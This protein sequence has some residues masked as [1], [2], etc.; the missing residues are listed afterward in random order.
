MGR[1][2]PATTV[3][4]VSVDEGQGSGPPYRGRRDVL[5]DELRSALELSALVGFAVVQP[6]LGPFGESPETFTAAGASPGQIVVFAVVVAAAPLLALW[7]LGAASRVLGTRRRGLVQT[8]LVAVLAGFA[9]AGL[10]RHLGAGPWVRGAVGAILVGAVAVVH[11]RWEPGRLFLRYASPVPVVLV[12][13]FLLASPVAPL[14]RP[15]ALEIETV[16]GGDHPPVTWSPSMPTA[17]APS[18]TV[19]RP[20]PRRTGCGGG[21]TGATAVSWVAP[22]TSSG[23]ATRPGRRP[24][25]TSRTPGTI[26]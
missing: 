12:V 25:S 8:L 7:A 15:A 17:S 11:R 24:T 16:E 20:G 2:T 1:E 5:R 14:V 6:V 23:C 22:S 21:A 10:A 18:S 13:M 9:G 3:E 26:S 4:R 19:P